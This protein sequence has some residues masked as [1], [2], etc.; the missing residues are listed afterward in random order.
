M[1]LLC[2]TRDEDQCDKKKTDALGKDFFE[3]NFW[4]YSRTMFDFRAWHSALELKRYLLRFIHHID[5]QPNLTAVKYTRYNQYESYVLPA[6]RLAEAGWRRHPV[7]DEGD[8]RAVRHH[9]RSQSGPTH[10]LNPRRT[11]RRARPDGEQLGLR[12]QWLLGR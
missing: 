7:R 1:N 10:R 4:V 9:G 2:I 8:Q 3:S 5:G 6:G 11:A 12:H